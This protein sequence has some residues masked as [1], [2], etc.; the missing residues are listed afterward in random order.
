[1]NNY[2]HTTNFSL[3]NQNPPQKNRN[4]Y[5]ASAK[6]LYKN[7]EA[8]PADRSSRERRTISPDNPVHIII[9]KFKGTLI[10]E[11]VTTEFKAIELYPAPSR[12]EYELIYDLATD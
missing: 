3:Y 12:L 11:R 4:S 8:K 2:A 1:M 5:S 7:H 6:R 10:T 9:K